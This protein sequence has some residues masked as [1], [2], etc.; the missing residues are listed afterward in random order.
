MFSRNKI[1]AL[2]LVSTFGLFL[3]TGCGISSPKAETGS[4][5]PVAEIKQPATPALSTLENMSGLVSDAK[6]LVELDDWHTV[7]VLD[8]QLEGDWE[9]IEGDIKATHKTDHE[10]VKAH[11]AGLSSALQAT[12]PDKT[13]VVS[14]LDELKTTLGSIS[15]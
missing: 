14:H 9:S 12:S 10:A 4:T 7:R 15:Q 1:F 2:S 5:T 8:S 3:L 11:L 6:T 13:T